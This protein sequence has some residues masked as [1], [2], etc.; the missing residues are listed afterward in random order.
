MKYFVIALSVLLVSCMGVSEEKSIDQLDH[1]FEVVQAKENPSKLETAAKETVTD[2]YSVKTQFTPEHG[3]G[4]QILNNGDL[5]INQP[6]IPAVAGNKGFD[7]EAKA[8]TTGD[9][10]LYK[11]NNGLFPPTISQEELDSLG[12]L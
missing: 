5:Y 9:F 12:V 6:H 1:E 2:V 7:S 3:W 10:I 4:Y 11:L 8:A